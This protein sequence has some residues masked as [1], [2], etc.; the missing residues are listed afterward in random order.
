MKRIL[1]VAVALLAGC[2]NADDATR[3]LKAAG[4][5]EIKITGYRWFGCSKDDSVHTGFE[6]VGRDGAKV[7]GVVCGEIFFKGNTI[8]TD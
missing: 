1:I 4:Y 6:A 8:R 5:T 2:T 7:S 3:A